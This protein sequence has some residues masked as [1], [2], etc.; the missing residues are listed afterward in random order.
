MLVAEL[1]ALCQRLGGL[2]GAD[3]R[4]VRAQG[5]LHAVYYGDILK[6]RYVVSNHSAWRLV[7]EVQAVAATHNVSAAQVALKWIV[8][9]GHP[10][11][12]SVWNPEYMAE[13]LDLWSWGDLSAAE[14]STLDGVKTTAG[15]ACA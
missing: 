13:D 3:P 7:P 15:T 14:M 11:A 8:Q 12:T 9:R 10:L 2:A 5:G 4:E 6:R 1:V